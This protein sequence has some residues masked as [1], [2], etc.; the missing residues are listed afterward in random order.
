M[1]LKFELL[2]AALIVITSAVTMTMKLSEH[3]LKV[4]SGNKELEF[5]DT[6]FTEVTTQKRIGVSFA[7]HGV[8]SSGVLRAENVRY[9]N[10][11]IRELI[12]DHGTYKG[13]LI[14][15]DGNV[16]LHQNEGFDYY[17]E[18]AHYNKRSEILYVTSPFRAHRGEDVMHGA[19]LR[20]NS[21]TKEAYATVVDAVLHTVDANVS[22][23]T[24]EANA[25]DET[26]ETKE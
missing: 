26:N 13:M 23:G 6:T 2:L 17:T 24:N 8:R 15:L 14:Y 21:R 7:T 20:Y 1:G 19:T 11:T 12:A 9:Y 22:M 3:N 18:H 16:Q 4:P 10:D 5:T 25:T